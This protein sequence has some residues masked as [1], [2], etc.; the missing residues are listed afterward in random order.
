MGVSKFLALSPTWHHP[1]F[2][3]VTPL[4]MNT[5]TRDGVLA[6][7]LLSLEGM[8]QLTPPTST[9]DKTPNPSPADQRLP[10]DYDAPWKAIVQAFLRPF[11]SFYFPEV[12]Q[13]IDWSYE[14][15]SLNPEFQGSSPRAKKKRKGK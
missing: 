10:G 4:L 11:L 7:A 8:S 13:A 5:W 1:E 14:P 6:R 9:G 15:R 12:E 2:R 3:P